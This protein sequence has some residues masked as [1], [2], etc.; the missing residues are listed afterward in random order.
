L[1]RK[2]GGGRRKPVIEKEAEVD[3]IRELEI[4]TVE[5][6]IKK[7]SHIGW[8]FRKPIGFVNLTRM[9]VCNDRP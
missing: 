2:G 5:M 7:E 1:R 6:K 9:H 4:H 3:T 8:P